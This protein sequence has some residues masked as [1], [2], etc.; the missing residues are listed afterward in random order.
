MFPG[1]TTKVSER[2]IAL[3]T[4]IAPKEDVIIVT[5]TSSTTVM[6]TVIPRA[7]GFSTIM[8]VVNVSGAS[9]TTVTTGNIAA[10]LTIPQNQTCVFIFSKLQGKWYPG[11]IS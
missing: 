7:G 1:L 6:T 8:V 11:A 2:K 4:T 10:A 3:A 5:D 9:I